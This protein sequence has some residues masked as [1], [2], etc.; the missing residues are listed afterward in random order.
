MN[1]EVKPMRNKEV[2][3]KYNAWRH[4][5]FGKG[6]TSFDIDMV[7]MRG[8][9]IVGFFEVTMF[10][11]KQAI[12]IELRKVIA[13]RAKFQL[14]IQKK[15]ADK[16]EAPLYVVGHNEDMDY[17]LVYDYNKDTYTEMNK[18]EYKSF[19]MNLG[20]PEPKENKGPGS[21]GDWV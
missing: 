18:E 10:E 8:K 19:I 6:F 17:F 3:K 21:V 15:I 2:F 7:E 4:I 20:R 12:P 14:E 13:G 1:N 9:R 16:M 5:S 11:F